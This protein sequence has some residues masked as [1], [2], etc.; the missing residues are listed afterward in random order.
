MLSP[1]NMPK[2][3]YT[4]KWKVEDMKKAIQMV[5]KGE[6]DILLA[7]KFFS[8]PQHMP[9][10]KKPFDE[11][12]KRVGEIFFEEEFK[13]WGPRW[14]DVRYLGYQIAMMMR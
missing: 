7:S 4:R 2:K 11:S 1:T 14:A 12:R 13:Y 5:R 3:S 6:M 9:R 10:R 8:V